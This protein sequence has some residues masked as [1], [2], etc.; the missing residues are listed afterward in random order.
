MNPEASQRDK[1]ENR[2]PWRLRTRLGLALFIVFIPIAGLIAI[3]QVENQ[4]DRRDARIE[5]FRTIDQT[6]AAVVDGFTRDMDSLGLATTLALGDTNV[7]LDQPT[8]GPYL[9]HVAESY[10]ILRGL[11]ITDLNGRV[12]ASM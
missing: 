5:S 8:M 10:G 7:S 2:P 3:S 11:F 9:T 6:I 1:G 12:T 4:R